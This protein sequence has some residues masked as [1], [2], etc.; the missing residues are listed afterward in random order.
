LFNYLSYFG[1]P[2]MKP[3]PENNLERMIQLAEDFFATNNDPS[4]LSITRRVMLRLKN[5]HPDTM[6]EKSTS[7]GPIAWILV[8]PSTQKLMDQFI[9]KKINERELYKS[10]PLHVK[11][12]SIYLCSAL[13]LPE[14]RGRGLAKRLMTKAIRSIQK[15]HPIQCLYSWAF[16]VGGN[17]LAASVARALSL[18]LYQRV[19]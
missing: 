16:S 7:R 8:I 6:T 2:T 14:Y 10:V 15:E 9:T 12:D 3:T 19:S 18:P 11:Y 4:Q 13:V 1:C 17:K 5:I